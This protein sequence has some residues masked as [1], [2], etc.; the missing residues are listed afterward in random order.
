[1]NAHDQLELSA[2]TLRQRRNLFVTAIILIMIRH[3]QVTFGESIQLQGISLK[4]GNP[5]ELHI[6]MY[7]GLVYSVWRF[8]QYFS[9]DKAYGY[10]KSQY[11]ELREGILNRAVVKEIFRAYPIIKSLIGEYK[12]KKA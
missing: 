5:E 9:T 4:I 11:R 2:G 8:Y 10:V 1:L 3:A 12:Y 7:V 6:L